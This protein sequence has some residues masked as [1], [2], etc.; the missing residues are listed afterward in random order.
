MLVIAALGSGA[1]LVLFLTHIPGAGEE[2]LGVYEPLPENLGKWIEDPER[3]AEG[4]VCERRTLFDGSPDGPG[5]FTY[6]ERFR[7]PETREIVSIAPE[8]VVK[9]RRVKAK[10]PN[11]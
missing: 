9:R 3:T 8:R 2:R 1:Y 11:S 10:S 4:L 5:K 7:K 6:Q